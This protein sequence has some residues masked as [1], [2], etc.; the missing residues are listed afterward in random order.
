MYFWLM[1][2]VGTMLIVAGFIIAL[3]H[4]A[5]DGDYAR[6]LGAGTALIG[7]GLLL[8]F[9]ASGPLAMAGALASVCAALVLFARA[10]LTQDPAVEQQLP[11]R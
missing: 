1:M 7:L 4:P 8:A 11:T 2:F 9:V 3:R 5:Q 6:G 10:L